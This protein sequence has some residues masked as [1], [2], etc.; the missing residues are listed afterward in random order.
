MIIPVIVPMNT[1]GWQLV[2]TAGT[3][4]GLLVVGGLVC[5]VGLVLYRLTF[6][7]L[8][9]Y[10][11]PLLGRVTNLYA[12][13]H[14]WKGDIHTDIWRCHQRYGDH[15]RYAPDRLTFNTAQAI[16]DIYGIGSRVRKS[17]VYETL[18]HQAPNTLTLRDKK[19]HAQRRRIMSQGFSDAAIRSFEP[20]VLELVQRLCE[21]LQGDLNS[22]DGKW[23]KGQDMAKWFDYL[24]FD[25]M[26]ALVFSASYD[27]LR[28]EKFRPIINAIEESNVRVSVILQAPILT[29]FRLDKRLFSRSI[30]WRNRFIKFIGR[31]VSER[32]KKTKDTVTGKTLRIDEL[33]GEVATLI[34]AGSDTTATTL[35][36]TL[37]YISRE[38][39]VY[40]RV[41][42]E[43]RSCFAS[44]EEIHAG[45]QLNSCRYLRACIDEAL[46][47]SPPTGSAL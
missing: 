3:T 31:S 4:L 32:V 20:R 10:P 1:A 7:P 6:H 17:K 41:T 26:S 39:S 43:V 30:L 15:I 42:R 5:I 40:E 22:N 21:I 13:Y 24:T 37:F 45:T 8:A 35:A 19:K 36:A 46:R 16:T 2:L 34:V 28:Q 27:T 23:S 25:I 14:A 47:L 29:L 18:V 12:A 9:R 33:G 44:A 38:P 11:G